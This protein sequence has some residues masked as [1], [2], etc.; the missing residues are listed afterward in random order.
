M[1]MGNLAI[2]ATKGYEYLLVLFFLASFTLFYLYFTSRRFS[3]VSGPLPA[4]VSTLLDWFRLPADMLFHQGHTWVDAWLNETGTVRVGMDD[5][6]QKMAG[7][8]DRINFREVG[9]HIKQGEPA[10][11]LQLGKKTVEMLSPI[12]GKVVSLNPEVLVNPR[13]V[14]ADPFIRGWL[15]QVQPDDVERESKN[16]FSGNIARKWMEGATERLRE[17]LAPGLGAV[18]QDGGAPVT[19]MAKAI[20]PQ[21]W[22]DLL[23][24]FFHT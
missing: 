9:S 10:W 15:M 2:Y 17:V 23:R 14:N 22:D 20:S 4:S 18:Y 5:F 13:I 16:L 12:S 11:S 6:A 3:P 1:T 19:G 8:A 21:S 7:A 24:R